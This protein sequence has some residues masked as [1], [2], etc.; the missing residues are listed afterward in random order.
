MEEQSRRRFLQAAGVGTATA[1][2]GCS[3]LGYS[4]Q[5]ADP[6]EPARVTVGIEPDHQAFEE[7]QQE[8]LEQ[9]Q[10]GEID[11]EEYQQQV[12]ELQSEIM[13]DATENARQRLEELDITVEESDETAG[14]ILAEGSPAALIE[15]LTDE[16]VGA[17]LEADAYDSIGQQGP[18]QP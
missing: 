14:A 3:S 8:L 13:G 5:D 11:E 16:W 18:Q 15:T 1:V 9:A 10:A 6:G 4:A 17:L 7:R 2:A 12:Q